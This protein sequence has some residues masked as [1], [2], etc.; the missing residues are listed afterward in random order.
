[1]VDDHK[2]FYRKRERCTRQIFNQMDVDK[3]G[4]VSRQEFLRYMLVRQ[5]KARR[6]KF[7]A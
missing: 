7:A 5:G 2:N 3:T 4:K 1:M 6:T